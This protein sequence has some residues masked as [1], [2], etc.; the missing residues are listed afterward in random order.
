[1]GFDP[2]NRLHSQCLGDSMSRRLSQLFTSTSHYTGFPDRTATSLSWSDVNYTLT[3]TATSDP[4]YIDGVEYVIS[5][6]TKQIPDTTGFY[7]FWLTYTAGAIVLNA[8]TTHPGFDVCLVA[9]V[10]WNT[11]A[12]KGLLADERH[13]MGR[14]QWT[15]EYLHETIGMRYASGLAG[16]FTDTTITIA[17][18]E[19]YDEDIEII[20]TEQTSVRVLYHDGSSDWSWDNLTTPYK[21]VN[22]GVDNNLRYNNG[23]SLATADNNKYVNSW[24]FATNDTV[25]IY[26]VIGTAQYATQALANA[27]GVPSLGSLPTAEAKLIY[28][29]MYQNNGGTPDYIQATDYR[30]SSNLPVS[31]YVAT[32]HGSLS[33][34]SDDD[35][36]QYAL[37]DGSRTFSTPLGV[38]AGGTGESSFTQYLILYADTTGSLSQIS[39]GSDG[40]V[41]TSGGAG[42]APAF[43][44]VSTVTYNTYASNDT[45]TKPAGCT[46]VRVECIGG[47][48]A[49]A[50]GEG[51]N[52]NSNRPGGTGGGGGARACTTFH[53]D[54]LTATVCRDCGSS[55]ERRWW[56]WRGWS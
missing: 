54:D 5:T 2:D 28:K 46:Y 12:N 37:A 50:G 21:V 16:T 44:A 6:L 51:G 56:W 38:A 11:T 31:N 17:A 26:V 40:Q 47:G 49:G 27:A 20:T 8:D 53:A 35:H 19:L 29:V 7:W 4:I 3:L 14:D 9:T 1:M 24:I 42:V 13:W 36:T 25:P 10:Y 52:A 41:L 18:G 15:H 43:E 33:G 30:S 32:D 55:C 34:L 39:I 48:G 45:W 23:T 22:P